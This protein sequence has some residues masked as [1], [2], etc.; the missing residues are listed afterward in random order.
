MP[1]ILI[2]TGE[3]SGDLHGGNL[4]LAL[5]RLDPAVIL[6]GV[7]GEHMKAAGVTLLP[8]I[9]RVD[10]VGMLGITQLRRGIGNFLRLRTFL[11]TT[12]LDAV[13]FIDSPGLNLRLA[14]VAHAFG[15]RV[16]YY[17][18]PQVWAWGAGRMRLIARVVDRMIVILPFEEPLFRK[19]GVRCDFV[20]HPLMDIVKSQY[21]KES[22]RQEFHLNGQGPIIGMLPGSRE[23]EV[24][25]LLPV[26][27]KAIQQVAPNFPHLQCL[28]A[29]ASTITQE[30]IQEIL[31][32]H[33]CATATIVTKPSEVM[34]VSDILLVASGTATLQ[35]A[36][37]GTPM[38]I[39]YKVSWL[40]YQ[41]AKR[42]VQVP[43]I[44]LVNLVAGKSVV[45]ELIQKE[46]NSERL[47]QEMVGI[48]QGPETAEEMKRA[49]ST[50]RKQLGE[51]GA[52]FRAA[53][54]VLEECRS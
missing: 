11:K 19:A 21:D 46:A 51:A 28:V 42:L 29:R 53:K 38:V 24:C 23:K 45:P 36:L 12:P 41:L 39:V 26:M 14:R 37:V 47:A 2:V 50:I 30:M 6:L 44:G 32:T 31:A 43:F 27:I 49:F 7:G 8:G 4:A 33:Q 40:T 48:L 15:H 10:A 18:A 54:I 34:A 52:S 9:E 17:I 16:V 3:A 20:G 25:E 5:T 35:A 22:L 13:V 1:R